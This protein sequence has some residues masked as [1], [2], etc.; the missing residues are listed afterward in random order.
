M[1]ETDSYGAFLERALALGKERHPELSPQH[2]AAF[3][4]S[5]ATI[6]TSTSGGYGGPS[7]REHYATRQAA[8]TF[9][10]AVAVAEPICYGPM[11]LDIARMLGEDHFDDPQ[12]DVEEAWRLVTSAGEAQ[13]Y[14]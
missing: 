8:D 4:N 1:T 9:E 12:G 6:L 10:K 5:V 13:L 11:T 2:H 14:R 3:A 7:L